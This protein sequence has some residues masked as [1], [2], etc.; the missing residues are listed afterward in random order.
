MSSATSISGA[1]GMR[2]FKKKIKSS[3]GLGSSDVSYRGLLYPLGRFLEF[4]KIAP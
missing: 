3:R 4:R 2:I 1:E